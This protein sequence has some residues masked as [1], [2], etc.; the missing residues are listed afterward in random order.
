MCSIFISSKT[1][2]LTGNLCSTDNFSNKN[3][4]EIENSQME[5]NIYLLSCLVLKQEVT[6]IFF[7]SGYFQ[8]RIHF[9]KVADWMQKQETSFLKNS[10]TNQMFLIFLTQNIRIFS[11]SFPHSLNILRDVQKLC[12]QAEVGKSRCQLFVN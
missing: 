3:G 10:S 4:F 5:K 6:K 9:I 1:V 8:F 7:P 2:I 11:F 12:W